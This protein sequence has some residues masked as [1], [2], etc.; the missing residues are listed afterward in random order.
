MR[1]LQKH[2]HGNL[3]EFK[4]DFHDKVNN[5]HYIVSEYVAGGTLREYLSKHQ[6]LRMQDQQLWER[7]KTCFI[8]QL[9]QVDRVNIHH[10][11]IPRVLSNI[12]PL[13]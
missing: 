10:V 8:N 3:A 7:I 11:I 9:V 5:I 12:T 4:F 2:A 13:V 1:S 6:H